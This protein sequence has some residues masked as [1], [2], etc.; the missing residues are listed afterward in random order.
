LHWRFAEYDTSTAY[1]ADKSSWVV[2]AQIE[3]CLPK[4]WTAPKNFD[5]FFVL[6][7]KPLFI[8]YSQL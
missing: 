2:N 6:G 7:T 8:Q 4:L 3:Y 1:A 5:A